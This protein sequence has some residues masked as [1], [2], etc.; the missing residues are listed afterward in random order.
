MRMPQVK[1][2]DPSSYFVSP[3]GTRIEPQSTSDISGVCWARLLVSHRAQREER[4]L[5]LAE[6]SPHVRGRVLV[7]VLVLVLVLVCAAFALAQLCHCRRLCA[8]PPPPPSP[9]DNID[10]SSRIGL[11]GKRNL[12]HLGKSDA[13]CVRFV[14]VCCAR[15]QLP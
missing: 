1:V 2:T 13:L 15:W 11:S 5:Q 4:A 12:E 9:H 8:V 7:P 10:I 6:S 3:N 14:C